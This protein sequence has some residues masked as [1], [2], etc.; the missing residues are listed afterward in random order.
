MDLEDEH[1]YPKRI[2]LL[3]KEYYMYDGELVSMGS[4]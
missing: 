1:S 4:V 3:Q 2:F